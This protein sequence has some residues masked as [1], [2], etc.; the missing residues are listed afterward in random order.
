M[1]REEIEN[2]MLELAD[3]AWHLAREYLGR[4]DIFITMSRH[5]GGIIFADAVEDYDVSVYPHTIKKLLDCVR[6]KDGSVNHNPLT[7]TVVEDEDE[8]SPPALPTPEGNGK[9]GDAKG[10]STVLSVPDGR[11]TVK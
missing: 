4:E 2:Q 1:T 5:A 8:K 6:Y 11:R 10:A 9:E 7:E 3:K